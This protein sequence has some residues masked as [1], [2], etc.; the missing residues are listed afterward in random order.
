[1]KKILFLLLFMP[2]LSQ[3]QW[4]TDT[5]FYD[6]NWNQC[7]P[8]AASY[9][10][11]IEI[12]TTE[13]L[14]QVKDYYITGQVQMKGA[15]RSINPDIKTGDFTY[16]HKNGQIWIKC[17][18]EQGDLTGK[19]IEWFEN[20]QIKTE[21]TYK[22]GKLDGIEKQW[23][24][25]GGLSKSI[26]YKNGEKDGDFITFYSNGLPVRKDFY[27]N[28]RL[29]KGR[30]YTEEGKDTSYFRYFIMPSFMGGVKGF[31]DFIAEKLVF[32][33][34]AKVNNEEGLVKIKFTIDKKG[35]VTD[36]NIVK[37]DKEYFN[38]EALRV[39]K[40]LPRWIPGMRDGKEV[41]VTMTV[42]IYFK[43]K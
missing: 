23:D 42:P 9:Y 29:I 36:V 37:K 31:K 28:D 34:T 25:D 27:K 41:E 16:W 38:S 6:S 21:S 43:L 40:E 19:Y 11:I 26:E 3:S 5:V 22:S 10:R 35:D 18:F 7:N 30:C 12:D 20:G 15:F 24:E 1:M 4:N 13:I 39:I 8:D 2:A 17:T 33:D 14:F 32:P